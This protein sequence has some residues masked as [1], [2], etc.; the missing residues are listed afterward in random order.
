MELLAIRTARFVGRVSTEELNPRGL[1]VYPSLI[2]GL[3]NKYNFLVAPGEEDELDEIKGINFEDGAWGNIA[4]DKVSIFFN[5]IVVHTRSSTADAEK[6]FYEALQWAADSFG[7]SY[8]PE[9]VSKK[10]YL[11]EILFH[12]DAKLSNLNPALETF[13]AKISSAFERY[14]GMAAKHEADKISFH[15]DVSEMNLPISAFRVERAESTP[16]SE[17]K[18]YS[19]APLPTDEHLQLI[20]EFESILL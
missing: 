19:V 17:N 10:L 8:T 7:L 3:I 2:E 5:G 4:I 18:Y 11:S 9:M 1:L 13:S 12:S 16:F 6:I 14:T 15:L 20:E